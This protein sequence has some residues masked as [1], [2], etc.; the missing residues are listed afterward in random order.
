[1][2]QVVDVN[3]TFGE[4]H[5]LKDVTATF[6]TGKVNFIIGRSGSGKS[7]TTKCIVGLLEV[8]SGQI[9]YDGR[10]FTSMNNKERKEIRKEIGMLFQG[11]ALFDSM[12]VEENVGF[13]LRMFGGMSEE[14]MQERINFCLKRV[15]L[16]GSNKKF[17]AEISGGMQKRVG[18]A[19]AIA[20]N[21]KYLF[22]DEPNSGLDPQTAIVIDNLIHEI[23]YE[24][25]MTTV[26][27]SHDMNSVI[28]VGDNINFVN[29]GMIWWTG[30]KDDILHSSNQ[31]LNDFVYASDFMKI[32]RKNLS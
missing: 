10:D 9:L 15:Q 5:V 3:K 11:S 27:V 16:E 4:Q 6:Q 1:M 2:I 7:V 14:E 31:E 8:D 18:I 20:M 17:P 12:T 22:C 30:S 21:P 23:T 32:V 28:E 24:F 26:V 29:K 13:P 25:K 19:R